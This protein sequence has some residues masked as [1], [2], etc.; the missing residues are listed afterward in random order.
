LIYYLACACAFEMCIVI[1]S[2]RLRGDALTHTHTHTHT[3]TLQTPLKTPVPI[4]PVSATPEQR[5]ALIE[6][7]R[8]H[9]LF[10]SCILMIITEIMNS[11]LF[12]TVR[13]CCTHH[14]H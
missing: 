11:R 4:I 12:T 3:H 9:P 10:G 7:R 8:R 2:S 6:E 14:D 5:Q 13:V 1:V